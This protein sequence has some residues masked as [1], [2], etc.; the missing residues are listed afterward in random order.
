MILGIHHA[1][2]TVSDLDRALYF[3]RDLLG[4]ELLY[5][6]E[7]SG[8]KETSR[9]V[10]L[11]GARM[12]VAVLK[13]GEDQVELIEYLSP[14]GKPYDRRPCDIGNMHIAFRVGNIKAKYDELIKKGVRFNAA[15]SEI[16]SG[17]MKGWFWTY[18]NDFDG[19]QLELVEQR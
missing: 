8:G 3:Y 6:K 11:E 17:P 4:L 2:V 19:S 9:G 14:K 16:T 18:F 7:N 5:T 13:A 12:R 15:P 10:G 1:S